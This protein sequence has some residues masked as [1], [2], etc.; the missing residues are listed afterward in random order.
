MRFSTQRESLL[1]PM[2]RVVGVVERRQTLPVLANLLVQV[3]DG[4]LALT[5]TDLEVEMRAGAAVDT[6]EDGE[7]TVP[8]RKWFDLVRALPDGVKVDVQVKGDRVVMHAGRSRYTLASLPANDFR[9]PTRSRSPTRSHCPKANFGGCLSV[10]PSRW[11]TRTFA[12]TS[13]D[14]CWTSGTRN[15]GALRRTVTGWQCLKP[16]SMAPP[17]RNAS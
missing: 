8:A 13:T 3:K 12:T 7:I 17:R 2:Q 1:K 10:R 9:P 14:C 5:G 15:C 4:R 6:A 16:R 11:R